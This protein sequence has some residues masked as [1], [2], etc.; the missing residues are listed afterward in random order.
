MNAAVGGVL[1]TEHGGFVLGLSTKLGRA[2]VLEAE[3][4]AISVGINLTQARGYRQVAIES[5]S[6]LAV[7]LVR[8]GCP[9][10]HPNHNLVHEIQQKLRLFRDF[11]ISHV[12]REAN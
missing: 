10:L 6:L 11:T 3:L 5:D 12:L 7:K 4:H 9:R 2:T 1:R 8:N